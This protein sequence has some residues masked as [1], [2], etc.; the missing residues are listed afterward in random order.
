[1][2]ASIKFNQQSSKE[3]AKVLWVCSCPEK[4]IQSQ[5]HLEVC[6]KYEDLRIDIDLKN[7]KDIVRY[8]DAVLERKN[9]EENDANLQRDDEEK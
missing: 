2:I 3:F 7:E 6:S 5:R 8:F 9:K 4:K 1:M